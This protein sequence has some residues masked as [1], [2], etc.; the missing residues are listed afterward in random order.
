MSTETDT[1]SPAKIVPVAGGME[2]RLRLRYTAFPGDDR[3]TLE[4]ADAG[5]ALVATVNGLIEADY[6][7]ILFEPE[8]FNRLNYYRREIRDTAQRHYQHSMRGRSVR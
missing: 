5:N 6:P 8:Y 3:V 1:E 7:R 4:D 2:D